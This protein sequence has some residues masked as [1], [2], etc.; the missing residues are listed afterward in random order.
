MVAEEVKLVGGWTAA[1]DSGAL[2]GSFLSFLFTDPGE[3]P[4][5]HSAAYLGFEGVHFAADDD[6]RH[7]PHAQLSGVRPQSLGN[8]MVGGLGRPTA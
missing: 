6:S 7:A 5:P 2:L 1:R 4:A 8:A 3:Q